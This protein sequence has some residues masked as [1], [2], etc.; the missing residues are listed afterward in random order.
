MKNNIRAISKNADAEM[1]L[2]MQ[3][4]NEK[5]YTDAMDTV[6]APA[7]LADKTR[8]LVA[9][10]S[11]VNREIHPES[12]CQSEE[13]DSSSG[14]LIPEVKQF[15]DRRKPYRRIAVA[16]G[17][18]AAVFGMA[19]MVSQDS[20]AKYVRKVFPGF[21]T[22]QEEVKSYVKKGIYEDEDQHIRMSVEE[23]LSDEI[24]VYV[25]VKYEAKDQEGEK[26]LREN[27]MNYGL[28][29]LSYNLGIMPDED[30]PYDV[31]ALGESAELEEYRTDTV[32]YYFMEYA[33]SEWSSSLRNCVLCYPLTTAG[34]S[35]VKTVKLDTSANMPIYEYALKA[36]GGKKLS[37]FYE[38]KRIRLSKLTVSIYGK[39]IN[40]SADE[41]GVSAF[42]VEFRAA[43]EQ[44]MVGAIRLIKK[45][46]SIVALDELGYGPGGLNASAVA[47]YEGCDCLVSCRD[48]C[49]LDWVY[50]DNN[51]VQ[52]EHSVQDVDLEEISA[53][54]LTKENG[55]KVTYQFEKLK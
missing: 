26:W 39:D 19:M 54:E 46:G 51:K 49:K 20:F 32:R 21:W 33:S 10:Q 45:D 2:K 43:S 52:I 13:P 9:D 25:L 41:D 23:V 55:K 1:R 30:I 14:S 6:H 42:G 18:A 31:D 35:S 27:G 40:M 11:T 22:Q 36:E 5:K 28:E 16:I 17:A 24:N 38:P 4:M 3:K 50:L 37:R 53:V 29:A 44:E 12:R 8:R 34:D 7:E 48:L 47:E 15:R